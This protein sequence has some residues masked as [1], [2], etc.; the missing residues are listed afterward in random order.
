MPK[1]LDEKNFKIIYQIS[2]NYSKKVTKE[3]KTSKDPQASL[4]LI[5]GHNLPIWKK[6]TNKKKTWHSNEREFWEDVD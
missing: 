5:E 4:V 6:K 1:I 2:Q 3:H